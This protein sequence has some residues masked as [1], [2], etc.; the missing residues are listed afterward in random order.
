LEVEQA[1]LNQLASIHLDRCMSPPHTHTRPVREVYVN[2]KISFETGACV[3]VP[4]MR[5]EPL[6][7]RLTLVGIVSHTSLF[8]PNVAL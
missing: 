4:K 3:Q 7:R 6:N 8:E 2:E 5:E 1:L